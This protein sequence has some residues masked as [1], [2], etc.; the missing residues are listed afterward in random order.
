MNAVIGGL[1]ALLYL[2]AGGWL[3]ARLAR[4]G[5]GAPG[6]KGGPLALGWGAALLH[7][8][9]AQALIDQ[10]LRV[11]AEH[12]EFT[13]GL[14]GGVFQNRVLSELV[15][16]RL[17]HHGFAARLGARLPANDAAIAYGQV[18]EAAYGQ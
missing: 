6:S 10:T 3:A 4:A 9:L 13:V 15:L 16:A 14:A 1:A 12:G 8:S 18:I 11:R 2:L 17:A 5:A 7:A